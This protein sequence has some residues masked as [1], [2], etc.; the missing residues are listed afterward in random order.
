VHRHE[1]HRQPVWSVPWPDP[2]YAALLDH[3]VGFEIT[4]TRLEGKFKLSQNKPPSNRQSVI[5]A[6]EDSPNATTQALA[7]QMLKS[8]A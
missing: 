6:L 2:R 8:K 7:Q 1:A 3:I 5:E 4:L